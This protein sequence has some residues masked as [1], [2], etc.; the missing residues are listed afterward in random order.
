M[1][2]GVFVPPYRGETFPIYVQQ[3]PLIYIA[4]P[5]SANP[6]ACVIEAFR[7][8]DELEDAHP[9][10]VCVV[11]HESHYRHLITPRPWEEWIR[12]DLAKL[13]RCDALFRMPGASPGADREVDFAV[14]HGIPVLLGREDFD[15]WIKG[16]L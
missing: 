11:P 13:A 5:Y 10:I 2:S 14:D 16:G 15:R 7:F 9:G 3:A 4:G 8:A 6:Q 1:S 12:R